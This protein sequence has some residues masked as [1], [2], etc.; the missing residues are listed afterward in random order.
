MDAAGSDRRREDV[1]RAHGGARPS[2]GDSRSVSQM[3]M[4]HMHRSFFAFL[5]VSLPLASV[6]GLAQAQAPRTTRS[7]ASASGVDL[8]A[9]NRAVDPCTDFFQFACGGRTSNS[10][11]PADQPRWGRFDELQERNNEVL[12]KV[13]ESAANSGDASLQRIG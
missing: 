9:L 10:P 4:P 11:I 5:F 6:L 8:K 1:R 3:R 7:S 13:L 12:H 2:G